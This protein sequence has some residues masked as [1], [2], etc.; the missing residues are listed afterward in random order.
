[1]VKNEGIH[2]YI[3]ISNMDQVIADEE[4]REYWCQTP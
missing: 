4:K 3:N 1:M 2:F